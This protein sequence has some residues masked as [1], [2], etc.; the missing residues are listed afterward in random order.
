MVNPLVSIVMS[1]F[2]GEEYVQDAILSILNQTYTNFELIV[3]NDCSTDNTKTIILSNN[4]SRITYIENN[5]NLGLTK[6]L[7]KGL[8]FSN[9]K[10]IV[11]MDADDISLPTR[12]E[13]QVKF[14]EN[15][16]DV[17]VLATWAYYFGEKNGLINT[18]RDDFES[19]GSELIFGCPIVHPSVII[20]KCLIERYNLY[21]DE[22]IKKSQDYDLWSR[23]KSHFPIRILEEPL[24]LYRVH[25]DQITNKSK[26]QQKEITTNIQYRLLRELDIEP[27][28]IDIQSHSILCGNIP[29][30]E[31]SIESVNNWTDYLF[32]SKKNENKVFIKTLMKRYFIFVIKTVMDNPQKILVFFKSNMFWRAARPS[33]YLIYSKTIYSSIRI[34]FKK[35]NHLEYR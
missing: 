28:Y 35:Y 20:R 12:I 29:S 19:I 23:C 22:S 7:N 25:E 33:N 6:S 17:G 11:R 18:I 3:I 1:V 13:K 16:D 5:E 31:F 10:Y 14:M 2:N 27:S 34:R 30:G 21:Y 8:R 26:E 9:G 32:R 4:D 24:L 15:N